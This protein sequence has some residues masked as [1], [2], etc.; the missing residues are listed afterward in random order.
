MGFPED[1]NETL[2]NSYDMADE[3]ECDSVQFTTLI[4]LPGTALFRQV[5]KDK[6]FVRDVNLDELWKTPVSDGQAGFI[7]KPYNMSL[8]DLHKW[9][10]KFDKILLKHWKTNPTPPTLGRGLKFDKDGKAPRLIYE[11]N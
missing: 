8:D 6:L 2:Q 7:I 4:P 3:L 9:R 11:N 1:T 10:V 5:V